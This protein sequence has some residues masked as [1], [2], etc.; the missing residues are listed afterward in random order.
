MFHLP[1][2]VDVWRAMP[3]DTTGFSFSARFT[4]D[5]FIRFEQLVEDHAAMILHGGYDSRHTFLAFA[6]DGDC[7][8]GKT[9]DLCACG[10]LLPRMGMRL[11]TFFRLYSCTFG[12]RVRHQFGRYRKYPWYFIQTKLKEVSVFRIET[13]AIQNV[14]YLCRCWWSRNESEMYI[15]K[16]PKKGFVHISTYSQRFH[17]IMNNNISTKPCPTY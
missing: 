11:W 6:K 17:P 5:C 8:S 16:V 7:W 2:Q 15:T 14:L 9:T 10:S 3:G 12:C 4:R 13:S 1:E